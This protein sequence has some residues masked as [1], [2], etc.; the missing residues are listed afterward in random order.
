MESGYRS[1]A[2][3]EP[4]SIRTRA[5]TL[6]K[7]VKLIKQE[8]VAAVEW[9]RDE[10]KIVANERRKISINKIIA[11]A[12][13]ILSQP[14]FSKRVEKFLFKYARVGKIS[15]SLNNW[16]LCAAFL[17]FWFRW[18]Y[19]YAHMYLVT[20]ITDALKEYGIRYYNGSLRWD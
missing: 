13:I 8:K 14:S 5:I 9:A 2:E 17:P 3:A 10:K 7:K 19:F 18:R 6:A 15:I 12:V 1:L 4:D 16:Q 20:P 11:K